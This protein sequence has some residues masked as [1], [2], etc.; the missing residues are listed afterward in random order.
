MHCGDQRHLGL[1]L[2]YVPALAYGSCRVSDQ[3]TTLRASDLHNAR[4]TILNPFN[5]VHWS[6]IDTLHVI[7]SEEKF[8]NRCTATYAPYLSHTA[9][10]FVI[11]TKEESTHLCFCLTICKSHLYWLYWTAIYWESA[12]PALTILGCRCHKNIYWSEVQLVL[13]LHAIFPYLPVDIQD[14]T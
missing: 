4:A 9:W 7:I 8:S 3:G 1:W 14:T 13:Y 11:S 2:G 6:Q 10:E 5:I 12:M